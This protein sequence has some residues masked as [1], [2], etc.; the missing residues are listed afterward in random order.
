MI[1]LVTNWFI[2]FIYLFFVYFWSIILFFGAQAGI[3]ARILPFNIQAF[4]GRSR[5]APIAFRE[6]FFWPCD[7]FVNWV[8]VTDNFWSVGRYF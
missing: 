1:Y 8:G 3:I 4:L 5:A 6:L 2:F 7:F